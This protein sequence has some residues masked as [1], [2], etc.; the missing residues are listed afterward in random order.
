M[1]IVSGILL[2]VIGLI[3][4]AMIMQAFAIKQL[5]KM[6]AFYTAELGKVEAVI[7]RL[8]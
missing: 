8:Q 4:G 3:I 7:D 6:D 1:S 5:E 2:F